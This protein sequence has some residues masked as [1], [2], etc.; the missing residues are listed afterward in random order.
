VLKIYGKEYNKLNANSLYYHLLDTDENGF[1]D[2]GGI[3]YV[4]PQIG[5][6]YVIA[7]AGTSGNDNNFTD[8]SKLRLSFVR[9]CTIAGYDT[10]G[11]IE[12][13]DADRDGAIYD[14]TATKNIVDVRIKSVSTS[15]LSPVYL[16]EAKTRLELGTAD[17]KT[18]KT[19]RHEWFAK[20]NDGRS[21]AF[22]LR[23][24]APDSS[25]YGLDTAT[26][27]YLR[28]DPD[29]GALD[30]VIGSFSVVLDR[31][32]PASM[33]NKLLSFTLTKKTP[34]D[35][36]ID[37][38]LSVIFADPV[39]KGELPESKAGI[40]NAAITY[41]TGAMAT[42]NGNFTNSTIMGHYTAPDGT[43]KDFVWDR[44]G[45]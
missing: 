30:T 34:A 16:F 9:A 24:T 17:L 32:F 8:K 40:F 12:I 35:A 23:G 14:S 27:I 38:Q 1:F 42:I 36:V 13:S 26:A 10:L 20:Y 6:A 15:P 25:F 3:L 5:F 11:L 21:E 31:D 22:S 4:I 18:T 33:N 7:A 29:S 44:N 2:Q 37:L 39:L 41:N 45:N 19:V 28:C 43:K